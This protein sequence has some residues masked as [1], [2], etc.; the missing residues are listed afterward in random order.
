LDGGMGL[1][2]GLEGPNRGKKRTCGSRALT[3]KKFQPPEEN[4]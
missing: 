1:V 3:Q 2:D 4:K